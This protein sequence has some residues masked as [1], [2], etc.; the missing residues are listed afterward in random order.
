MVKVLKVL[1]GLIAVFAL[2]VVALRVM[3]PLPDLPETGEL[4]D[5]SHSICWF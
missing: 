1:G 3:Y 4:P 5:P 2:A